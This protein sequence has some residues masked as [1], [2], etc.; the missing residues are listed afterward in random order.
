MRN[1]TDQLDVFLMGDGQLEHWLGVD[2]D[3]NTEMVVPTTDKG[4]V[5]GVGN[6]VILWESSKAVRD[7]LFSRAH[8][9]SVN[10]LALGIAG[11]GPVSEPAVSIEYSTAK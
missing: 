10:G 9:P 1:Q 4:T 8:A 6:N 3:T 7:S 5:S 11:D 2:A